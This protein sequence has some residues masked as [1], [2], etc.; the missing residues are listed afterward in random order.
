MSEAKR[1]K[2]AL[3]SV[4]HKEGLDEIITKLHEEGVEFLSTGGTRQ[5]IE[6]LGFP[7]KAVEDLTTYP[8]IL[9][10]RVK[11]LHPK[12]FGGIL[13]R[14]GLEQDMQQI[15]KYEIPE[16]DL[17]I[18]DL[19]PFE[20]TVASGA[21]EQAII[22]KIDI[23][24]I[25]LIRAAAKN[26][27]DV[28]II[29]SQAQYKPFRDMLL[30]HG[31]TTSREERRWFAKE[32]FA[33]SSH[34]DSA[35]FNYFDGGEGSAF[36]CAVEEQKQ[37][38]Y[39][40]NP[41]QKG[42]FYGNLDAMFDQIHGKEI[43]YNN[44]LDIYAAVDLIDELG[45]DAGDSVKIL[46]AQV[47]ERNGE[48][49]LTHWDGRIIKGD[50]DVPE[51]TQE[52]IKIG[53]ITE[54]NNIAI[55]GVI[56]KLQDIRTFTRKSDGSEGKLR[57]FDVSDDTGSIRTTIWGNDTDILL[58]K[59]D[60]VKIIGADAR[61]DDYTD[62]GYSLN[63][64]FNTQLS[65]NP[66]NLSDEELDIFDEIKQKVSQIKRLSEVEEFDEDGIEV[67]VIGRMFAIGEINE[68]QR[69]DGS[70]GYA[71][72]AKF[73]DGEGRV[74]LTFWDQK[75]KQE[76]KTG[77]AYKIEN[78]K[79]RLGMYEVELNIGGSARVIELPE[80]S[81]Q[82]R[83]LPSFKTIETMLYSHKSIADVEEDD[84]GII[85]TGR[86]IESSDV[87]EFDRTD[88]S[89]GYVKSLEIADNSGSINVTLWIEKRME[90]WRCY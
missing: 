75:A 55:K 54:Q 4:Y 26:F 86:I 61:F 7:C 3:V 53:D 19:Y 9:G 21:E 10:G 77:G 35:I 41:H 32:A 34:Y 39:G 89:K 24:G 29:A 90:C 51:F 62:S 80:D 83:F 73:S 72:S 88:G 46:G 52:F 22:E 85:V 43:S 74:G 70:V 67:D 13:C 20:A 25:S 42:Y 6:S 23:G 38:R 16:I 66:E 48:L 36:R 84:E 79:V 1:I 11:T 81:D 40:E 68:F 47:R 27:N 30:E 18:V 50:F 17:V 31:A 59:G 15:E 14:R 12:V 69:D 28:V 87:R 64:N 57:N 33:V 8:S 5:F 2:T 76:Y 65:I 63:T 60:I 44:L 49:S 78:A 56:S 71:R 82:A 37:L 58:T 45:L